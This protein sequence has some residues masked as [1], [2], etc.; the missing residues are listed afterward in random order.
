MY[1]YIF[2]RP[3][4]IDGI[5]CST[6]K[7]TVRALRVS[8]ARRIY[9]KAATNGMDGVSSLTRTASGLDEDSLWVELNLS[10]ESLARDP[11]P[12]I[13]TVEAPKAG[14]AAAA[15]AWGSAV[16]ACVSANIS[17][18]TEAKNALESSKN[19]D[20]A[21][22]EA[23]TALMG[24][25]SRLEMTEKSVR[26]LQDDATVASNRAKHGRAA[27]EHLSAFVHE[28]A[29]S[30]ALVRHIV[31]GKVGDTKYAA[32]LAELQKKR[33]VYAMADVRSAAVYPELRPYLDKLVAVAVGKT[34][35]LL[36]RNIALLRRP[37]TNVSIVKQ[38]VLLPHRA[39]VEFLEDASPAAFAELHHS[40]VTTMARTY[41]VLFKK[42]AADLYA[43]RTEPPAAAA[44]LLV[45]AEPT[46]MVA[47]AS[48]F[49]RQRS[50]GALFSRSESGSSNIENPIF[51]IKNRLGVLDNVN[52]PAVVLATAQASNQ[53]FAYEEI[54]RSIGKMLCETCVSEH[55]FCE[56][57]FG[58][59]DGRFFDVFFKPVV[60]TLLENVT[61]YANT[62][63]DTIGVLLAL[64]INEAQRTAMQKRGIVDL[65]D[66][67]IQCDIALKPKFKKL[68]DE[69]VTSLT[70]ASKDIPGTKKNSISMSLTG[71]SDNTGID[72]AP[73]EVTRKYVQFSAAILTI[74]AFGV[75]DDG[76]ADGVRRLRAEYSAFLNALSAQFKRPKRRFTFLI[77]NVDLI[78]ATYHRHGLGNS[79]EYRTYSELQGVHTAAFVEH[80]VADHFPDVVAF[81]REYERSVKTNS[82]KIP[83]EDRVRAILKE[84]AANWKLAVQHMNESVL[85][86]FASLNVGADLSRAL[87]ARLLAYHKRS[88]AAIDNT[89]P[90]LRNELVTSTEIV[91]ELRQKAALAGMH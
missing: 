84:F 89:Y 15:A 62:T 49:A 54:H 57:F 88:E 83:A 38:S 32:C 90:S 53:K 16:D 56:A 44:G 58:D 76:V 52:G 61:Q 77:N 6:P 46:G 19:A 67:F 40:Y 64:K 42:Y 25:A 81:V 80:E 91:Y 43:L 11:A 79:E 28:L 55:A 39:A 33:A 5:F 24:I 37:N 45:E 8:S 59:S 60:D 72:T 34:R 23:H 14:A 20:A 82:K 51:S 31:D 69:N 22:S 66:F 27:H 48:A 78:L 86:E 47:T 30:P 75:A 87:F 1:R 36:L 50:I 65:A 63:K 9:V 71:S 85:R 3:N 26:E 29:L 13:K 17:Y 10:A 18:A 21:L 74:S 12:V 70:A 2:L 41:F 4:E 7:V 35:S 73:H 68:L